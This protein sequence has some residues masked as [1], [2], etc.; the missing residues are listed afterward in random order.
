MKII[1]KK[2]PAMW[3]LED[4]LD[5]NSLILCVTVKMAEKYKPGDINTT[6]R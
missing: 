5:R 1:K 6:K 2:L 3:Y 4:F